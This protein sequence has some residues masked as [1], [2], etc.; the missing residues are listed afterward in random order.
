ML[1]DAAQIVE[2]HG[3]EVEVRAHFLQ[4]PRGFLVDGIV[5]GHDGN[6][7]VA[8][9]LARAQPPKKRDAV[10]TRHPEIHKHSIGASRRHFEQ[11]VLGVSRCQN[12][13][14]QGLQH[15][16]KDAD[17][18]QVV[19]NNK[20]LGQCLPKTILGAGMPSWIFM[21]MRKFLEGTTYGRVG[22]NPY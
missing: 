5:T 4:R 15:P 8:R 17:D 13:V 3:L 2:P 11:R 20:Y 22:V 14:A 7:R 16:L 18:L 1:N 12:L 10:N 9:P 6:W 21:T 19:V